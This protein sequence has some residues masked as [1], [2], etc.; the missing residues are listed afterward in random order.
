MA[1]EEQEL[2]TLRK[3]VAELEALVGLN[4]V[5]GKAEEDKR[6][7][8]VANANLT[9]EQRTQAIADQRYPDGKPFRLRMKDFPTLKLKAHS[10]E[11]AKGRYMTLCG[12]LSIDATAP[13]APV[14]EA[15]EEPAMAAA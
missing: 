1:K 12:I 8:M 15:Q 10:I 13:N 6:A 9:A 11:E 4:A 3:R 14:L 5:D 7:K 2:A